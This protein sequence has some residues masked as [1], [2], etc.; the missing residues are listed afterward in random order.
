MRYYLGVDWADREHRVWVEDAEG[1]LVRTH[2][3][4]ETA[5]GWAI[6]GRWLHEHHAGGHEL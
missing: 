5:E 1:T 3:V 2:R 6:W 4:Q